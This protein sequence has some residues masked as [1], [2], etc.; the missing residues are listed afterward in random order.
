MEGAVASQRSDFRRDLFVPLTDQT[1]RRHAG[2][3][4]LYVAVEPD[5]SALL[6]I[7]RVIGIDAGPATQPA[8][9]GALRRIDHDTHM[10][11]P[12]H[13][14]PGLRTRHSLEVVGPVVEIG[15]T[16]VGIGKPGL[17]ID[18]VHQV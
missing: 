12:N 14:V 10:P 18:G 15:R 17:E 3:V 7:L 9:E 8:E 13:Q 2:R 6:P 11:R 5:L 16:R 1:R 4:G